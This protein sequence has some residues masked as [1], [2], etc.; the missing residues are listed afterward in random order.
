MRGLT[1]TDL[2]GAGRFVVRC[3]YLR[4]F[5]TTG[6]YTVVFATGLAT[7]RLPGAGFGGSARAGMVILA[8]G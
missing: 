6:R 2:Q 4:I 3:L 8:C 1:H 5:H 7:G